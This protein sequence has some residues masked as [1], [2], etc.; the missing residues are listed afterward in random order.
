MRFVVERGGYA[1]LFFEKVDLLLGAG[2]C[3][4]GFCAGGF[5]ELDAGDGD[6]GGARVPE[7]GLSGLELADQEE[8]LGCGDPCL[9]LL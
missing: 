7:D 2:C 8:G 4:D 6:G 3:V 5:G 1:E 9:D